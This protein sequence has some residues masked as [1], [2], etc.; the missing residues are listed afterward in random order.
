MFI[1]LTAL[2][3]PAGNRTKIPIVINTDHIVYVAPKGQGA[4]IHTV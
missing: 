2:H 4:Y 3:G 1:R